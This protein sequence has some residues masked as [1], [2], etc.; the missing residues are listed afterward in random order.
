MAP[1]NVKGKVLKAEVSFIQ[2]DPGFIEDVRH[3]LAQLGIQITAFLSPTLGTA[4]W[5][6]HYDERDKTPVLLDV[7]YL[8]T[9]LS[10]IQGDAIT[11]HAVLPI[12]GGDVTTALAEGLEISMG[13]AEELKRNH[14]F[15]PDE[16]DEQSD[17]A[18]QMEDGT[19]VRF[20]RN[21]V[22]RTI[23][24]VTDELAD[25]VRQT[26]D[27][28][29][30]YLTEKSVIYLTGGGLVN[31]RGAKEYMAEKLN[32]T[33]RVPVAKAARLN[34]PSYASALGLM[35]LVFDEIDGQ[36]TAQPGGGALSGIKNI[37]KH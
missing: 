6:M 35:D 1:L 36:Q 12:G 9:E 17:P 10:V 7:G 14:V 13:Q 3:C 30:D 22:R 21:L 2:A 20:P 29:R 5:L 32:R 16:F 19:T 28:C 8:N 25:D 18:V 23:E 33:V 26:L 34:N 31:M 15:T 27:Y 37:F 4:L 24:S 11:F